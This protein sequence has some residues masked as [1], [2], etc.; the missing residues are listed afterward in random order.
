MADKANKDLVQYNI[1]NAVYSVDGSVV[2]PLGYAVALSLQRNQETKDFYGDG[3]LQLS[4]ITDKGQSGNIDLTAR[5]SD[6]EKDLGM[7]M[8]ITGGEAEVSVATNKSI[9]I[10]AEVI[11]MNKAGETK[12]K[13]CWWFG[14]SVGASGETYNQ[15][16][17][18]INEAN[19]SYPLTING[20]DLM[21]STGASI[22]K[23]SNGM[24]YKCYKLSA[25]PTDTGYA[26]FLDSV[27]A[28][29][30]KA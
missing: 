2:K 26:T 8:E 17:T 3:K 21:D 19:A 14:V 24:S 23:D 20:V 27:P 1:Q 18:T 7:V 6:F 5:D 11:V 28:V 25:L 12:V 15:T 29:K 13:K 22:Y 4:V 9:S 10:G 16:T 30:A